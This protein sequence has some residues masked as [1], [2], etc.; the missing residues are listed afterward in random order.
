MA[1]TVQWIPDMLQ[2]MSTLSFALC[3][4]ARRFVRLLPAPAR[5]A[6]RRARLL[7]GHSL[8]LGTV[9][10]STPAAAQR[11]GRHS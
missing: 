11:G 10:A 2:E 4:A 7:V 1:S 8:V 9:I 5:F 3:T 6:G